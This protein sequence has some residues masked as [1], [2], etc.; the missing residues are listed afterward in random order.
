MEKKSDAEKQTGKNGSDSRS[1][2]K[3]NSNDEG[4]LVKVERRTKSQKETNLVIKN[5]DLPGKKAQNIAYQPMNSFSLSAAIQ[6]MN[7][8]LLE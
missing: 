4:F 1:K 5:L 8:S 2:E 3:I 6:N 7:N